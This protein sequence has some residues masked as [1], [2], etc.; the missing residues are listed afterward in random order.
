MSRTTRASAGHSAAGDSAGQGA[1]RW[2]YLAFASLAGLLGLAMA[3][4]GVRL[5]LLGGTAYYLVAGLLL[6]GGGLLPWWRRDRLALLAFSA[7]VLAT[8]VWSM[9]EI[10]G[11]G[12]LPAWG[13][14]LA[15]RIGLVAGLVA[16]A[17]VAF[18]F[19][20]TPPGS[21]WRRGAVAGLGAAV[22]SLAGLVAV[23]WERAEASAAGAV[24]EQSR[25]TVPPGLDAG[26]EWAAFGGTTLGRRYSTL[27]QIHTGNVRDLKDAWTFRS[28]DVGPSEGRV[29]YSS[30]NTPIKAEDL[31]YTCSSS[32]QV[33]ALD[34]GTG[35]VRWHFDPQ[36]PVRSMESLFSAACRAVAYF[37]DGDPAGRPENVA[38][39]PSVPGVMAAVPRGGS[40]CHRR[41][42]VTTPDGRLI[43]LDAVAGFV[44]RGFGDNGTVDLTEGMGLR[45]AGFA[46]NTS[47]ATVAGGLL[48][49]GQQVSDNQRRDAPSGV[50]RAYDARTGALR[51]AW[52]ALRPDPQAP[53]APGE[54]FPRGTPNV[55]NVVSADESLGLAF[56]GTGN[57]GADHWGGNRSPEEDRFTAAVVAVDLATGATRWSFTTVWHDLWDYDIG[58]QPML[59]DV[60]I[61][62]TTRRA[63]LQG[64]KG[65]DLFLLDAAT[66]EPLRPVVHRA[67][68][69]DGSLPGERVAPTQPRS[70]FFPN[71]GGVPGRDPETIDGRH[72]WG[73]TPI[74]AALCRIGFHQRRYAG[75]FT[76]PT[77]DAKGIVLLPGTVGGMNWGGLGFDPVRRLVIAN[78]SRLP[79]I[80]D[81][82][83]RAGVEDRPVGSGG[84]RPDQ[85]I[86]PHSGTPYGVN[87]PMWLSGL[88]VP[89]LAPPWGFIAA[90]HIDTGELVWSKPLGTGFDTGPLGI[91]TR[92]KIPMGTPNLGGPLVTAGGLTFIAAA[93]DDFLR[94]FETAT[95]RLLW[96][97]RL[98]AGG[99]AGAMSYEH[100]GRQYIAI[101]ATGHARFETTQGDYLKVFA[102][103]G[104]TADLTGLPPRERS[105]VREAE[106]ENEAP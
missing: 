51:W 48:V 102:L 17:V 80:V 29:F 78:Y 54:I 19:W 36:V 52:D 62:G 96:Q 44:C 28:G 95:G 13:F 99:Q 56:L 85:P 6:L 92:L 27:A 41:V 103:D 59:V 25:A 73:V 20:R 104:A 8:L 83:P 65:G 31:L 14:D 2:L 101:T 35:E 106:R 81:M 37:D 32:N 67:V 68:P 42:F 15:A 5:L 12:W 43:A 100:Q 38:R 55:W 64:T 84:A 33:H 45:Q 11:K 40:M 61:D 50:V 58:A 24:P 53:L 7:A 105:T 49:L 98:P 75:S 91:P 1:W 76:P 60:S 82:T 70:V 97:A 71:L 94:A 88:D 77:V 47:G 23:H 66:G 87:R 72:I 90:T 3:V 69:Q 16:A 39:M 86:A 93:Q 89:C 26:G 9:V 79:N 30:Q 63:V 4:L 21:G 74:D 10:G 22:A 18:V 57:P 34:P 46:S